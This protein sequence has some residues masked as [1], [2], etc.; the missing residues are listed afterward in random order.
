FIHARCFLSGYLINFASYTCL[1]SFQSV[2]ISLKVCCPLVRD[3]SNV[4]HRCRFL[5]S[6]SMSTH[7]PSIYPSNDCMPEKLSLIV[8]SILACALT[9]LPLLKLRGVIPGAIVSTATE[10]LPRL[11]VFTVTQPSSN[12]PPSEPF[13]TEASSA[14]LSRWVGRLVGLIRK[15]YVLNKGVKL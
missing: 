13:S 15:L 1:L 4:C 8:K 2:T 10:K 6:Y 12:F 3:E 14:L 5:G 11:R 7:F 9:F